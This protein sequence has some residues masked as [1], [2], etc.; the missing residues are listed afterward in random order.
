[1]L[2]TKGGWLQVRVDAQRV[3]W[4]KREQVVLASGV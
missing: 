1:V 2:D 4:L 3:G